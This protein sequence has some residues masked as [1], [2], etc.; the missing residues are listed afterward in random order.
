MSRD[1][2]LKVLRYLHFKNN[3]EIITSRDSDSYN[4]LA[5]IQPLLDMFREQCLLL[6][7]DQVQNI[8]EQII[9]FKDKHALKQYVKNKPKKMGVQGF[10]KEFIRWLHA[11]LLD[12]HI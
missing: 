10:F 8:D 4:R 6:F 3:V 11:R 2:F 9:P 7:P 1:R 5:K 12:L